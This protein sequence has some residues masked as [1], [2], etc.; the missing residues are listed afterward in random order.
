MVSRHGVHAVQLI[1][2]LHGSLVAA[3]NVWFEAL[4]EVV[5]A[6]ACN[7]DRDE[8]EDDCYDGEDSK[9]SR[10]R[11]VVCFSGRV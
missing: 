4:V 10:R 9:R 1:V 2:P 11:C 6:P 7:D 5:R 8:E 3:R